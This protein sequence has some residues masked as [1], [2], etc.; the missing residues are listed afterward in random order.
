MWETW[1]ATVAGLSER[2]WAPVLGRPPARLA[3]EAGAMDGPPGGVHANDQEMA[4]AIVDIGE[5]IHLPIPDGHVAGQADRRAGQADVFE[6]PQ[7]RRRAGGAGMAEDGNER[8]ALQ[9][10]LE[11]LARGRDLLLRHPGPPGGVA[12]DEAQLERAVRHQERDRQRVEEAAEDD[13]RV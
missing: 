13:Q 4:V 2:W 7:V 9:D 11:R 3:A 6:V 1:L 8:E 10:L 5:R 12:V